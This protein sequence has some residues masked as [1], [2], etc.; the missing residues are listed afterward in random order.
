[1]VNCS[2]GRSNKESSSRSIQSKQHLWL[3]RHLTKTRIPFPPALAALSAVATNQK[4]DD[5]VRAWTK[6]VGSFGLLQ[7]TAERPDMLSSGESDEEYYAR[8][9]K[10]LQDFTPNHSREH[11]RR[12]G[13]GLG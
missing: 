6:K 8:T 4:F 12:R 10:L 5:G 3:P 2:S 7:A 13:R 11:D 9:Q 1:M